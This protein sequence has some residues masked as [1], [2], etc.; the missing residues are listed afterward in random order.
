MKKELSL[1]DL[2]QV[3]FLGIGGI[4]MSAIARWFLHNGFPVAGYD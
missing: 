2:K 3:Y 1:N 4:G